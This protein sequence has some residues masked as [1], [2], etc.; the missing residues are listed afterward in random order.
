VT[1]RAGPRGYGRRG[2]FG[3]NPSMTRLPGWNTAVLATGLRFKGLDGIGYPCTYAGVTLDP[4]SWD[5]RLD[6]SG[7]VSRLL[8]E[9]INFHPKIV[10]MTL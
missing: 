3:A 4:N 1:G 5:R 6:R 8:F 2:L 9:L 10:T 7:L